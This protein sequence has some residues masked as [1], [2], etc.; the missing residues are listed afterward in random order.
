MQQ[1]GGGQT[2]QTHQ[3]PAA[4]P[5]DQGS[6]QTAA[7]PCDTDQRS[8]QS[9]QGHSS[10]QHLAGQY[11]VIL[12]VEQPQ[13]AEGHGDAVLVAGLDHLVVPDAAAGLVRWR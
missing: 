8:R 5:G 1:P 4:D 3:Q 2:G 7:G 9:R 10:R 13:A 12:V 6:R 11:F